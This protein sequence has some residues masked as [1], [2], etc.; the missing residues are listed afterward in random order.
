MLGGAVLNSGTYGC[1]LKPQVPCKGESRDD[2]DPDYVSKLMMFNDAS[3]EMKEIETIKKKIKKI[4]NNSNYYIISGIRCCRIGDIMPSDLDD[5]NKKC[6]AMKIRGVKK[7]HILD[8]THPGHR[9]AR[10]LQIPDGGKDLRYY[11]S[12]EGFNIDLFLKINIA[13]V[14]LLKFGIVPLKDVDVIHFD[15]KAHNVVYSEEKDLARLIDWGLSTVLKGKSIPKIITQ[16]PI[17]FNQPFTNILFNK[18]VRSEYKKVLLTIP[19]LQE[20]L[21]RYQGSNLIDYFTPLISK[22]FKDFFMANLKN[23]EEITGGQGHIGFLLLFLKT[24]S[25]FD[26]TLNAKTDNEALISFLHLLS[27]HVTKAFLYSFVHSSNN[28]DN[29]DESLYFNTIFKNNCDIFGFLSCY[30]DIV[31]NEKGP[32]ALREKIYRTILRPFYLSDEYA[33]SV[34]NVNEIANVLLDINSGYQ[35]KVPE[36]KQK[37][38]SVTPKKLIVISDKSPEKKKTATTQK[39]RCPKGMRRDKKTQKCVEKTEKPVKKPEK[40]VKKPEK[41]VEKPEKSVKK[42]ESKMNFSWPTN[43]RC[44]KGSQRDKKTQ[45]CV[46][47]IKGQPLVKSKTKTLKKTEKKTATTQ[48]KTE[49]SWPTDKRCPK[50]SR[51]DKKTQKCVQNK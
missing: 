43:Q 23:I 12:D 5:Y 36:I 8:P 18:K 48:K 24:S 7:T 2:I 33:Y 20:M 37:P 44:P 15:I 4:P 42:P 6:T 3:V 34:Y 39:K 19:N 40:S 31:I 51:R 11:F 28:I 14:K 17:M 35:M 50:G 21:D 45:K 29:F 32:V 16:M 10:L 49:F 9:N 22:Y 41:S 46:K 13:M 30:V 1:I 25:K 27:L 26:T 38:I 47:K